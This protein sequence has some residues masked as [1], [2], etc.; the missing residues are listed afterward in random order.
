MTVDF[1]KLTKR[2]ILNEEYNPNILEFLNILEG[3]LR[4]IKAVNRGDESR[5][6]A[7]K[8][9]IREVKSRVRR[10]EER[11]QMLEEQVKVLEEQNGSK[12]I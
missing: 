3:N 1:H 9:I 11:V 6:A 7:A 2:F 8:N 12:Q 5:L 10:L 4:L